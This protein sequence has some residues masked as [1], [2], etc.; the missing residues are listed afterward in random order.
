[1]AKKGLDVIR[2]VMNDVDIWFMNSFEA[3]ELGHS[4]NV[5]RAAENIASKV[6]VR[7]L[8]V[9]LGPRGALLLRDDEVK[10]SDAFKVPPLWIPQALVIHSQ[11]PTSLPRYST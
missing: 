8:I 11:P 4:E 9:T 5:V 2:D 3:K 6:R 1:M 7:E 10:Y